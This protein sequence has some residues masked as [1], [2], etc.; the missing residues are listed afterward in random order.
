MHVFN[1]FAVFLLSG[2]YV[3]D[4]LS[5]KDVVLTIQPNVV[6]RSSNSTLR[7]SYDLQNDIL[8]SV[9]WYRGRYEF[10]R[11]T[12]SEQPKTKVFHFKGINVLESL[13]NS[14]HV[15]LQDID[16]NLSGNFSCEVTTDA[17][18]FST[19]FDTKTMLVV[20]LPEYPPTISVFG[21]PLDYGDIL[22]ANCTCPP[23]RPKA[24]LTFLLN[25]YTV[26]K[27][28]PLGP[29][30]YQESAWSDLS[31]EMELSEF[32]FNTGRLLLQCVAEIADVYH[33]EAVL[34]LGSVRDP[35]PER[36]SAFSDA[37]SSLPAVSHLVV[38]INILSMLS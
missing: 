4:V 36:V 33:E 2:F 6:Q 9:K 1:I 10:Y 17:P 34:K 32:H 38:F 37:I 35:V 21:E 13:S 16:F 31:L 7:C 30:S 26:A 11:F 8:Y 14:T 22:R 25:N 28:E 19:G 18:H 5:L 29:R 3:E 12:P 27:S 15:V 24:S 23:S 20:Q